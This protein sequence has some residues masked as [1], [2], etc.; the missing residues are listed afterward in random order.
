MK[1]KIII[2]VV[3][4]FVCTG[5][6]TLTQKVQNSYF[7]NKVSAES[8]VK[9]RVAGLTSNNLLKL[10]EQSKTNTAT[11]TVKQSPTN[12]KTV[13]KAV[14]TAKVVTKT[15]S[16]PA[17]T[18][19]TATLKVVTVQPQVKGKF[20]FSI[21]DIVNNKVIM[22]KNI[23]FSGGETVDYITC[24]LLKET[25]IEYIN[26]GEGG[27]NSYFYSIDRLIEK[28]NGGLSGWCYY[29]NGK[30]LGIGAGSYKCNKGDK[31]EWKY[32][33]DALNN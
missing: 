3:M 21:L 29:V 4:I 11:D 17:T 13:A 33:T 23:D 9:N 28:K 16:K 18:A 25:G 6:Y 27:S 19:A 30:K 12:T 26:E 22:D 14:E 20:N 8:Q 15:V 1:K 24:K 31:I 32:L 10:G 7:G 2:I 5:L